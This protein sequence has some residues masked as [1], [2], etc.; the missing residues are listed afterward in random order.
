MMKEELIRRAFEDYFRQVIEKTRIAYRLLIDIRE[1]EEAAKFRS[2][3]HDLFEE[4]CDA[5]REGKVSF[6]F[7]RSILPATYAPT[8]KQRIVEPNKAG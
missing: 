6:D 8:M 4:V 2:V 7:A 1:L 5:Y 3:L